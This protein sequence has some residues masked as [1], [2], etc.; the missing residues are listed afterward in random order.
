MTF[1]GNPRRHPRS[2]VPR[3][4][5]LHMIISYRPPVVCFF[6]HKSKAGSCGGIDINLRLFQSSHSGLVLPDYPL[7]GHRN[8]IVLKTYASPEATCQHHHWWLTLSLPIGYYFFMWQT[9]GRQLHRKILYDRRANYLCSPLIH[10]HNR[11]L[12]LSQLQRPIS[13]FK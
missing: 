3:P 5:F 6:F 1:Y 4:S 10:G 13:C 2:P 11:S 8:F 9:T 12:S 7:K